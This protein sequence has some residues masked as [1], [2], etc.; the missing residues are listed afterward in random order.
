MPTSELKVYDVKAVNDKLAE[1]IAQNGVLNSLLVRGEVSD[2]KVHTA[3]GHAYFTLKGGTDV[4]NCM[5]FAGDVQRQKVRPK[6][7]DK[8][9]CF[10]KIVVYGPQGKYQLRCTAF[11]LDGDGEQ[12]QALEA[13]KE[14]LY[15]EGLFSQHRPL[16][17][18]PSCVAVV[19]APDGEAIQDI[20]RNI[21]KRY[22]AVKL[23]HIH[24]LVQGAD[25]P[26]SIAEGIRKAQ[27]TDADVL[28]VGRGGGSAEDLAAFDSEEVVRAVFASRI[29]TISAV[30]HEGDHS[31]CDLAADACAST[32]TAAAV[33][34]VP[35]K[36]DI[37]ARLDGTLN[38]ISAFA[39]RS[40]S[41]KFREVE[42]RAETI[43]ALSPQ[44][45]I[46][47]WEQR[48]NSLADSISLKAHT[49]LD[50]AERSVA[51]SAEVISALN[52]LGVLARGFSVTYSG[53]SIVMSAD[54]LS[55]GDEVE[56]KLNSGSFTA[57]VTEIKKER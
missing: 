20:V 22:P 31:L 40:L 53:G 15:K 44:S 6:V 16:P 38:G 9:V 29:P 34:A 17:K 57:S 35:D 2:F 13:L 12:A 56:V 47:S 11:R 1:C 55:V 18:L 46:R 51:R 33:L 41:M 27:D 19:T 23:I 26:L 48:L 21:E 14:K 42:S 10:G 39:K 28:I 25:A 32:P 49:K 36:Y 43:R 30:G 5:M 52:P 7:G 24:S 4:L 54:S 45:R 8:I 37:F 3:K 50:R